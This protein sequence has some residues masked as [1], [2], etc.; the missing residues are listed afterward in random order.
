MRHPPLNL[1]E[2]TQLLVESALMLLAIQL[3]T[4]EIMIELGDS[5]A[6]VEARYELSDP[7][8]PLVLNIM[9]F[10]E[11]EFHLLVTD[12]SNAVGI[13][14]RSGL[15]RLTID[16]AATSVVI[17]YQVSGG[18]S[19]IPLAVPDVPTEPGARAVLIGLRGLATRA[20][21]ARGFPRLE[22][23]EDGTA[24]AEL[25]NLPGF[26]RLP[27]YQGQWSVSKLAEIAVVLLV[28]VASS[29]WLLR[30]RRWRTRVHPEG[31]R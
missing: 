21:L 29:H 20:A 27:P 4:A 11:Q 13:D 17:R 15:Y 26:V 31:Q 28:A 22:L 23:R 10:P 1:H 18:L 30:Q 16:S 5:T 14:T 24:T 12:P 6:V 7:S 9:R 2:L 25:D 8:D 19:R 3:S